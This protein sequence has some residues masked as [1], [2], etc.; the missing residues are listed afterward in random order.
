ML[1]QLE[2]NSANDSATLGNNFKNELIEGFSKTRNYMTLI[3]I[4]AYR[5][6][7]DQ[8]TA[9]PVFEQVKNYMDLIIIRY[10]FNSE[11]IKNQ[12]LRQRDNL[13]LIL[14]LFDSNNFKFNR[15]FCDK[16]LNK[17]IENITKNQNIIKINNYFKSIIDTIKNQDIENSIEIK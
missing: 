12:N 8:N 2:K 3:I 1:V 11:K 17:L 7:C 6:L 10:I 15:E 5:L 16:Q 9:K 13:K 14:Y 4:H